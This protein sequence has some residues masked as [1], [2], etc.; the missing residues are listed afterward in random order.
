MIPKRCGSWPSITLEPTSRSSAWISSCRT[1]DT[2]SRMAS[3]GLCGVLAVDGDGARVGQVD[4]GGDLHQRRLAGAVAAQQA[5]DLAG[6]DVEV[7][8]AKRPDAAEGLLDSLVADQHSLLQLAQL[9][10]ELRRRSPC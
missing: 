2:P 10:P 8:P 3:A 7:D 1:S 6:R 9:A 5:D 4:A